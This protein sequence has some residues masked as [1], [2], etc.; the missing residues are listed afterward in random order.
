M[1]EQLDKTAAVFGES[2]IR[3]S[4]VFRRFAGSLKLGQLRIC[5]AGG[6]VL[7]SRAT[8]G[9]MSWRDKQRSRRRGDSRLL[10]DEGRSAVGKRYGPR[11]VMER[12]A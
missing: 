2:M 9:C 4:K 1:P 5:C 12:A 8:R 10:E 3:D 11:S 7:P 6:K